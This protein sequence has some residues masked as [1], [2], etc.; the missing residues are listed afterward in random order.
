MG[1]ILS[2]PSCIGPARAACI[3]RMTHY[4]SGAAARAHSRLAAQ[5]AWQPERIARALARARWCG[6]A[7]S[8]GGGTGPTNGAGGEGSA[9]R[10]AMLSKG[11]VAQHSP[12]T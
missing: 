8:R 10:H 7:A 3:A 6:S 5:R 2:W 12:P 4:C 9:A 11:G 1:R